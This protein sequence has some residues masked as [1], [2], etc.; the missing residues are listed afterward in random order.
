MSTT[1]TVRLDDELKDRLDVLAAATHRSKSFLAADAIRVFVEMNE[2]QVGEI[3][4]ALM[5]ADAGGF[6]GDKDVAALAR[7]WKV[8]AG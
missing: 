4:A 6:A 7:K 5:G 8:N 2:W 1:M 3:R